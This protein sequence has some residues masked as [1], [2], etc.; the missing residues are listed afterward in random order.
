MLDGNVPVTFYI[1]PQNYAPLSA[2]ISLWQKDINTGYSGEHI[3]GAQQKL[4]YSAMAN[5]AK[6]RGTGWA[7]GE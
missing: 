6:E 3:Y 2:R 1:L 5:I 4:L 7:A